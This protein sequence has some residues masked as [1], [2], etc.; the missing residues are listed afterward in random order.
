MRLQIVKMLLPVA[1]FALASAGA[2]TTN[3]SN[4]VK[5]KTGLIQGYIHS[6]TLNDCKPSIQCKEA[7][8]PV[9]QSGITTGPQVYGMTAAPNDCWVTLFRP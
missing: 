4:A 2:V 5:A 9:C 8:G 3:S 1:A 7:G 6:P